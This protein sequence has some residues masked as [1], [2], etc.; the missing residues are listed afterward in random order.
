MEATVAV[1]LKM[2]GAVG[3]VL[4]KVALWRV[5]VVRAGMKGGGRGAFARLAMG[6]GALGGRQRHTS[7]P[8]AAANRP[9]R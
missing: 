4:H 7:T 2:L 1:P 3:G 5:I 9:S 8:T 6:G